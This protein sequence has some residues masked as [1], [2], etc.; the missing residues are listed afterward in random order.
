V[1]VFAL[2]VEGGAD[3]FASGGP[4][5][6]D[7]LSLGR[8][9]LAGGAAALLRARSI[10]ERAGLPTS[11]PGPGSRDLEAVSC[12]SSR[13]CAAV[14]VRTLSSVGTATLAEVWK[15]S[16]WRTVATVNPVGSRLSQLIGVSCSSARSCIAVGFYVKRS[17]GGALAEAWNG[18][19][20]RLLTLAN[21][22]GAAGSQLDSVSCS[23]A[24]ACIAVGSYG[25]SSASFALAEAWNGSTWKVLA[26]PHTAVPAGEGLVG[27]SC[28]SPEACTAVGDSTSGTLA[29]AW[30]GST[31]K[32]LVTPNPVGPSG[33]IGDQLTAVV[34][35]SPSDA[36]AVGGRGAIAAITAGTLI[37]H[38]NGS[39]WT[40]VSSP[41]PGLLGYELTGVAAVSGR[42]VWAVGVGDVASQV[43]GT[44]K[45]LALHWNGTTWNTVATPHPNP[46]DALNSVTRIPGTNDLWAAG[47]TTARSIQQPLT[48]HWSGGHWNATP[49]T[50][51]ARNTRVRQL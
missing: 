14:G 32:I 10:D 34:N 41:T 48:E 6:P 13:A 45:T 50:A 24:Q 25:T 43:G 35:L 49:A 38:W 29:E 17:H 9:H 22:A 3:G 33:Q 11:L 51:G 8:Q 5:R 37:E 42:D 15:G 4:V 36:W 28:S 16:A 2:F 30:N 23:S 21:P 20:W 18:T 27:V 12:A 1:V 46:Y 40:V 19:A 39:R 26:T 47:T 7:R 44:A 31:W